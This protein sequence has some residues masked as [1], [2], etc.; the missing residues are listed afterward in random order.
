MNEDKNINQPCTVEVLD[1][2]LQ[3]PQYCFMQIIP[4]LILFTPYR[5]N[6]AN[7]L[8]VNSFCAEIRGGLVRI[9]SGIRYYLL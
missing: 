2:G 7:I 9:S 1:I 3:K 8:D 6:I 5:I 4:Y